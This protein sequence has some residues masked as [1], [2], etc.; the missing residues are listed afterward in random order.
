MKKLCA[1]VPSSAYAEIPDPH[2]ALFTK[3][4]TAEES[5][6]TDE[7]LSSPANVVNEMVGKLSPEGE[8]CTVT[9]IRILAPATQIENIPFT[10]R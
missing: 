1:V 2:A 5:A 7:A 6:T 8:Y 3:N 9:S 4:A 10:A